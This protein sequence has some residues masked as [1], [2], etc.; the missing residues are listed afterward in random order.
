MY[1]G[2][3][4]YKDAVKEL[5]PNLFSSMP[6]EEVR[7]IF[8]TE[9]NAYVDEVF[10]INPQNVYE[11]ESLKEIFDDKIQD[12]LS[13][14]KTITCENS[15]NILNAYEKKD[16]SQ[17]EKLCLSKPIFSSAKLIQMIYAKADKG[18]CFN[19][20]DMFCNFVYDKISKRHRDK[21]VTFENH[22]IIVEKDGNEIMGIMPYFKY[23]QKN[24][25][26]LADNE[27]QKAYEILSLRNIKRLFVAYPRNED[28]TKHI[29]VKC[30]LLEE[31][32]LTLVPYSITHK[33]V[34]NSTNQFIKKEN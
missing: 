32:Q 20:S 25:P 15:K 2:F 22:L 10:R 13:C 21:N 6:K 18:L 33:V 9:Y 11:H 28:F 4:I 26:H 3:F 12:L 5:I 31:K 24:D 1:F 7:R 29:N 27:I 34:Y 16:F 30:S 8:I 17:L 23:M 14:E 19:A